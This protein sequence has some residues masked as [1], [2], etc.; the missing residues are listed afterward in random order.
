M[1]CRVV[2]TGLGAITPLGLGA[3]TLFDRWVEGCSGIEDGLGRCSEFKGADTIS[4]K[5]RKR[6]DRFT[7]LA[8]GAADEAVAE[9]T[10][11]GDLPFADPDRVGC[12]IGTG[13]GGM[14]TVETSREVYNPEPRDF[15]GPRKQERR[16]SPFTVPKMMCNAAPGFVAMRHGFRGPSFAV[17]SACAAGTDAIGTAL[18]LLQAGEMDAVLTGGTEASLT[19]FTIDSFAAM[20]ATSLCGVSRPFDARRDGFILSEGAGILVLEKRDSALARGAPVLG[21]I[22]GHGS[23]SD[24]YH[25]VAPDPTGGGAALAVRRA[26]ADAELGPEDIDYVNAHGT[27]TTLNDRSETA[28]LKEAFGDEAARIPVSSTKSTIGHL[29]GAAGAVEAIATILAL[30]AHVAPPTLNYSEPEE[31]LDLDYVP[32]RSK[33]LRARSNGSG[34]RPAVGL[35]NSFGFGGHNSVLCLAAGGS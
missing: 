6:T 22:L 19:E 24:A 16:V 4:K 23:S 18:R 17:V 27:S 7:Q 13:A 2:V 34:P 33:P 29:L 28:A 5:T 32:N 3:R 15:D 30:G 31:G 26:L 12:I 14:N 21:E 10:A 9:A 35:S 25:L 20:E 8:I 1:T 11:S